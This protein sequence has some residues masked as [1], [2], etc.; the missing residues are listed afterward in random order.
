MKTLEEDFFYT[1][2]KSKNR[3]YISNAKKELIKSVQTKDQDILMAIRQLYL[4][5]KNFDLDPCFSTGTFYKGIEEP[6]LKLDKSPQRDDVIKNDI[7]TGLPYM[8]STLN[9]I[10]FDPPFMF[11]KHGGW[12][13]A[14]MNIRF[15]MFDKWE[16]LELMYKTA[17]YEFH[18]VL[19]KKGIVAFKCQD[20]T[21]SKTTLT[22]CFVHNWATEHGFK[23]E[24]LFVKIAT[25]GRIW[26]KK[27]TQRHARKFHCYW[28]VLKK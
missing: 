15:T 27:L 16:D 20:Y 28:L 12:K 4:D 14:K 7:L 23:V 26:N 25:G 3:P 21:D 6:K 17:I 8:G 9:G 18:R 10:V 13:T 5:G 2:E 24:D 19:K 22:H 1:D 11:G